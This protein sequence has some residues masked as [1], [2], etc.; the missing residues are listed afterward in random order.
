MSRSVTDRPENGLQL[1]QI[2][3]NERQAHQ[4]HHKGAC[5]HCGGSIEGRQRP[6]RDVGG[7][8]ARHERPKEILSSH[9]DLPH[10][11]ERPSEGIVAKQRYGWELGQI[12]CLAGTG[13][14]F[15]GIAVPE[16]SP[17]I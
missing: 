14:T 17:V 5:P 3:R 12:H 16:S 2:E 7:S 10:P 6:S 1:L 13:M 9:M 11:P 4:G 8:E 15:G